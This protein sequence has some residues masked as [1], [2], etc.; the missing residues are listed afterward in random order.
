[1]HSRPTPDPLLTVRTALVLLLSVV[2]ALIAG[3]LT[4]LDGQ[5]FAASALASAAAGA[6][7]LM[8]FHAIIGGR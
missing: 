2:S 6:S 8:L 5:S 3:V 1:M 4:Y 7:G